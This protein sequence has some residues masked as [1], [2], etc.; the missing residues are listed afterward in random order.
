MSLLLFMEDWSMLL[1]A[2]T[3]CT[4]RLS[5]EITFLAG[6]SVTSMT[7]WQHVPV[8]RPVHHVL[9]NATCVAIY[10]TGQFGIYH[11]LEF[12]FIEYNDFSNS[13]LVNAQNDRKSMFISS[14]QC[15]SGRRFVH[16]FHQDTNNDTHKC[17]VTDIKMMNEF[18]EFHRSLNQFII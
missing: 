17:F 6:F 1:Q 8:S 3:C 18:A 14:G 4:R 9:A 10:A 15:E 11:C 2:I 7:R 13:K 16:V 5:K 12:Q